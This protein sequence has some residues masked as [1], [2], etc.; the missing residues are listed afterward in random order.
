[1][2][3]NA[4]WTEAVQEQA[5]LDDFLERAAEVIAAQPK[6][7]RTLMEARAVLSRKVQELNKLARDH[8]AQRS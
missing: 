6:P 5:V 7:G 1:M 8:I 2:F 3:Y 4:Q